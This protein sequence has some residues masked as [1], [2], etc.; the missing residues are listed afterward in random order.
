MLQSEEPPTYL[1]RLVKVVF[2]CPLITNFLMLAKYSA[3]L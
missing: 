3:S 2:E 1:P